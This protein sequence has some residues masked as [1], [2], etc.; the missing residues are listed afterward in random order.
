MTWI[1]KEFPLVDGYEDLGNNAGAKRWLSFYLNEL[2]DNNDPVPY[3]ITTL[4]KR[5]DICDFVIGQFDYPMYRGLPTDD[6][7]NNW[8][9]SNCCHKI[10]SDFW[11]TASETLRTLSL[12]RRNNKNGF[13][14]CE[15]V[16]ALL[17]TLFLEK[18]WEAYEC[19]GAVLQDDKLLGYHG[20]SIF[21]DEDGV[22]RLYAATLS[23]PPEYPIGY[24]IINPDDISWKVGDITYRAYIKFNREEYYEDQ[25]GDIMSA[26]SRVGLNKKETR[27]KHEALSRVWAQKTKPL[28]KLGLMSRLRWR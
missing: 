13:G 15:D 23:I 14:D 21:K 2:L 5:K 18:G 3:Y 10:T 9:K 1:K 12:N 17:I 16:S 26:L 27:R 20:W 7:F 28:K 4:D 24:P 6:H 25:S 22:W 11:Q 19:F 8:F